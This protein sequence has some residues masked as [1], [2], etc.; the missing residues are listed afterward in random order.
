MKPHF[1]TVNIPVF[2]QVAIYIKEKCNVSIFQYCEALVCSCLLVWWLIAWSHMDEPLCKPPLRHSF[3]V[4]FY[5]TL[6]SVI[7]RL[8]HLSIMYNR[9]SSF[10]FVF[11]GLIL[12]TWQRMARC[13]R[14][15]SPRMLWL[16][17]GFLATPVRSTHWTME[18]WCAPL[19]SVTPPDTF[20]QE[21]RVASRSGTLVTPETRAQ[22]R[23]WTVWWVYIYIILYKVAFWSENNYHFFSHGAC[24]LKGK[25]YDQIC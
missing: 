17:Q 19:P 12:F 11:L 9:L 3:L 1:F 8:F 2:F 16:A 5:F 18:R 15:L 21:G 10:F 23:S 25:K 7:I 22:C 6:Y 20:T 14:Y 4:S 24:L 13:S